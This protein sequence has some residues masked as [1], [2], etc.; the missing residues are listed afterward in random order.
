[1]AQNNARQEDEQMRGSTLW[2]WL[3]P[4]V[5]IIAAVDGIIGW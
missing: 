4:V 1:M 2:L 5:G 3:D